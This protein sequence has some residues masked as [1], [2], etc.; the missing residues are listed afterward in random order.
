[1]GALL[2]GINSFR[3]F[4]LHRRRQQPARQASDAEQ[5]P[6]QHWSWNDVPQPSAQRP[7]TQWSADATFDFRAAH[8]E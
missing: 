1:M 6:E 3:N 2:R 4:R 8:I 5:C 7:L